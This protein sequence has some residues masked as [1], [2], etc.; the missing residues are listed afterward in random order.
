MWDRISWNSSPSSATNML[1]VPSLSNSDSTLYWLSRIKTHTQWWCNEP[2]HGAGGYERASRPRAPLSVGSYVQSWDE[3]HHHLLLLAERGTV[4][5]ALRP[6]RCRLINHGSPASCTAV[7]HL[8]LSF[9]L[10][11]LRQSHQRYISSE[12]ST[13][14]PHPD[15]A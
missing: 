12:D 14:W 5:E 1:P 10:R 11:R 13:P 9:A 15:Q 2:S 3:A 4:H 8:R 7:Y 6:F